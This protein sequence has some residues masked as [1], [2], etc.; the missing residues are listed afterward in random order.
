MVNSTVKSLFIL[1]CILF[2][3]TSCTHHENIKT[4]RAFY[5]WK[6]TFKLSPYDLHILDT[7]HINKLYIRLFDVDNTDA[8]KTEPIGVVKFLSPLPSTLDMVPV[9]FIKNRVFENSTP[10]KVS[11]IVEKIYAKIYSVISPAHKN[12]KEIQIDCDWT[13]STKKQ[14]FFFLEK[15]KNKISPVAISATIRLHQ[16]KY[17]TLTGIPPVNRGMLMFYNMGDINNPNTLNSIYDDAS[18]DKYVSSVGHYNIPLDVALPIFS[19]IVQERNGKTISLLTNITLEDISQDSSFSVD[20]NLK[21]RAGSSFFLHGNYIMQGD[22]FRVEEINP[23]ICMQAAKK[24]SGKLL[25]TDRTVV[26]FDLDSTN[27][28][29]YEQQDFEKIF[30]CFL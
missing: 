22:R 2:E 5:Y 13:L 15:L 4:N 24:I 17:S 21:Y 29:R 16:V 8:D 14:Y 27:I 7:L 3:F 6:T 20:G 30:R 28:S 23:D 10:E 19:W 9:V 11:D 26:L 1:A 12:I 18:A 25:R